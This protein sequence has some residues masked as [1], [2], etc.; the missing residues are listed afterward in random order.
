MSTLASHIV[1]TTT[2]PETGHFLFAFPRMLA[3]MLSVQE[4]V[5]VT[6]GDIQ[7]GIG[8]IPDEPGTKDTPL[9]GTCNRALARAM[10][11]VEIRSTVSPDLAS[12]PASADVLTGEG[13]A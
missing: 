11:S 13:G 3:T 10:E 6:I 5:W 8:I 7:D 2:D 4:C 12:D 1:W 9:R